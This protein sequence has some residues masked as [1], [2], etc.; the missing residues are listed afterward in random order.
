MK[1]RLLENNS[2]R[3]ASL[4]A[5]TLA[6]AMLVYSAI[7]EDSPLDLSISKITHANESAFGD[8]AAANAGIQAIKSLR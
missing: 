8:T 6:S 3:L 1:K 2:L 4:S 5:Y 7:P